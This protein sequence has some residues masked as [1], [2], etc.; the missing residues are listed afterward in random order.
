[1]FTLAV[2]GS[3]AISLGIPNTPRPDS[4]MEWTI[5]WIGRALFQMS[6]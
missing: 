1:L 3:L 5:R 4:D 6:A 2:T